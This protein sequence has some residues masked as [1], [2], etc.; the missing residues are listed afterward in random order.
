MIARSTCLG[1]SVCSLP[2]GCCWWKSTA[3]RLWSTIHPSES[4]Y[5]HRCAIVQ[6]I[7]Q[8]RLWCLFGG[9]D[10][11]DLAFRSDNDDLLYSWNWQHWWQWNAATGGGKQTCW[12][13]FASS[14][15]LSDESFSS[16]AITSILERIKPRDRTA[17]AAMQQDDEHRCIVE[18]LRIL[19]DAQ[20]PDYMLQSILE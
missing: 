8:V 13:L 20:C 17:L 7:Q 2:G 3:S 18:I 1:T 14:A 9:L 16:P 19:E 4:N 10:N 6:P 5:E 11:D 12:Q 15:P